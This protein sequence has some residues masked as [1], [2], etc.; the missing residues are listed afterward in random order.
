MFLSSFVY[1]GVLIIATMDGLSG[2]SERLQDSE[3]NG[4]ALSPECHKSTEATAL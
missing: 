4:A 1:V 3:G 2:R